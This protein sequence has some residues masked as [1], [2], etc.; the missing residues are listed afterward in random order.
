MCTGYFSGYQ[1]KW[2]EENDK[3]ILEISNQCIVRRLFD[4]V[5]SYGRIN[6]MLF[7]F[8]TLFHFVN[9]KMANTFIVF[10]ISSFETERGNMNYAIHLK[11]LINWLLI[12]QFVVLSGGNT[13]LFLEIS[14]PLC[15]YCSGKSRNCF[16]VS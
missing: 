3:Q 7:H 8:L 5:H 13:F 16:F 9:N 10:E 11:K 14:A 2:N 1:K 6:L 4:L 12:W 15:T